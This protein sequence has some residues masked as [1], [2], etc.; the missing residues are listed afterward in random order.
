MDLALACTHGRWL[1]EAQFGACV[2][3]IAAAL[4]GAGAMVGALAEVVTDCDGCRGRGWTFISPVDGEH[5][6]CR[7]CARSREALA[8]WRARD[9]AGKGTT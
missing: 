8:A 4:T 2:P 3:C 9:E 7:K 6:K 1:G 5:V